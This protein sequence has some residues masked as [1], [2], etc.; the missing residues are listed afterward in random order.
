MEGKWRLRGRGGG[1]GLGYD[2][3]GQV[4]IITPGIRVGQGGH[5]RTMTKQIWAENS[6]DCFLY[7][8][9]GW[10]KNRLAFQKFVSRDPLKWVKNLH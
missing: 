5:D 7:I 4:S 9:S 6:L 10:V 3:H 2:K 8:S 1:Q